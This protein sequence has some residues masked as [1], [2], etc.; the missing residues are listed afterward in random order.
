MKPI[1]YKAFAPF[2]GKGRHCFSLCGQEEINSHLS[3]LPGRDVSI[4]PVW[5]ATAI[6]VWVAHRPLILP[7][8]ARFPE[9]KDSGRILTNPFCAAIEHRGNAGD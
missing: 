4:S 2:L 5:I 1:R 3:F 7:L 6:A 9:P 8:A